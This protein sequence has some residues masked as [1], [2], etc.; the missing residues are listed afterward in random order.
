MSEVHEIIEEIVRRKR[1]ATKFRDGAAKTTSYIQ[2]GIHDREVFTLQQLED[3]L[4]LR[5]AIIE[6]EED[7]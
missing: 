2:A 6:G 5:Y 4:R 3:Y 7:E 1:I